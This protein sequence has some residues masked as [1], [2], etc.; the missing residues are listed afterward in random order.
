[1]WQTSAEPTSIPELNDLSMLMKLN[2]LNS[3]PLYGHP[4][5]Y[6]WRLIDYARQGYQVSIPMPNGELETFLFVESPIM[7]AS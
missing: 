3:I 4:L 5:A 2:T 6:P 1:M 7:E